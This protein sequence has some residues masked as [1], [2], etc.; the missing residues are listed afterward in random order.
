MSRV[1]LWGQ[2]CAQSGGAGPESCRSAAEPTGCLESGSC[3]ER[4]P[5][6]SDPTFF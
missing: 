6:Y 3:A 4:F 5:R 2:V 1:L